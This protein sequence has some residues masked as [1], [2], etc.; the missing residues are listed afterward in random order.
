ME[1]LLEEFQGDHVCVFIIWNP[2]LALAFYFVA[3]IMV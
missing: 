2:F 3:E 1:F